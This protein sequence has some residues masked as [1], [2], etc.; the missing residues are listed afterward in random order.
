MYCVLKRFGSILFQR[1][2]GSTFRK[3]GSQPLDLP[4]K[5]LFSKLIPVYV[6]GPG[7]YIII[8]KSENDTWLKSVN[9]EKKAEIDIKDPGDSGSDALVLH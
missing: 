4:L 2:P 5:V 3:S 1:G 9:S 7:Y 6:S 8:W